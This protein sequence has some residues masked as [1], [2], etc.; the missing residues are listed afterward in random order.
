MHPNAISKNPN[1]INPPMR[2]CTQIN[3][4]YSEFLILDQR[5]KR[6]KHGLRTDLRGTSK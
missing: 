4:N 2:F 1:S 6:L 5:K 3:R